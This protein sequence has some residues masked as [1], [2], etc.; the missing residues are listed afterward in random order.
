MAPL[1]K[2]AWWGLAAGLVFTVAFIL[3]FFLMGGI[4]KFDR[5]ATFR[6]IIDVLI[7]GGLVANLVIVNI[8]LKKPG[9]VDERD[10]IILDRAPRLQWLAVVLTLVAWVIGLNEAYRET[11]LIPAVFLY[12]IFMS[13][14][15]VSTLAQCLGIITG[16]RRMDKYGQD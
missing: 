2:R 12:V 4:E 13:V 16:Y 1:Q 14:L 15:I 5:D 3:V 7:I 6:I 10:K 11:D 8:P 9:M